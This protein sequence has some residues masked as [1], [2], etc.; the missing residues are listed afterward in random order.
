MSGKLEDLRERQKM[1]FTIE[2]EDITWL[3]D[4]VESLRGELEEVD[5]D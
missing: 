3:L 2:P 5:D 1:G 4:E